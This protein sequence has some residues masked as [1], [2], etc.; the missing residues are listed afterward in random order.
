LVL[1]IFVVWDS[2][3]WILVIFYL[4][5]NAYGLIVVSQFWLYTNSRSDPRAM[6]RMG[7]VVGCAPVLE[8]DTHVPYHLVCELDYGRGYRDDS[9]QVVQSTNIP[10]GS[11]HFATSI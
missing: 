4:Y 7:G 6:K 2:Y 3:T 9:P 11:A 8:V 1:C 10:P 5:V